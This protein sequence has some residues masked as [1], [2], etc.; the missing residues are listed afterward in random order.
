LYKPFKPSSFD[1][2]DKDRED[3]FKQREPGMYVID[4]MEFGN[5]G[6]KHVEHRNKPL[7]QGVGFKY[8][9]LLEATPLPA[10]RLE[11]FE[12]VF[13]DSESKVRRIVH[14]NYD[15]LT[16]V[17]KTN[18]EEAVKRIIIDNEK[19]F[20]NFFNIAEPVNIRM[21]VFELLPGIGKKTVRTILDERKTKVFESFDDIRNRV[22]ID[23][24]KVLAKRIVKEIEGGEKYYVFI[25]PY[26]NPGIYLN[27]LEKLYSEYT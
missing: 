22:K 26:P 25:N 5:P 3:R 17:S 4:F 11:I 14:I 13:F 6:D 8:F 9:S 15:D 24:V 1:K 19:V 12:K 16:S 27:Y 23:P 21:H 7:A 10:V 2:K 18:L 20:V